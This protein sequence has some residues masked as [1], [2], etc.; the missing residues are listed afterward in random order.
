MDLIV[1]PTYQE[2]ATVTGLVDRILGVAD[3]ASFHVLVVDDASPDGT[4]DIVR[5]HP[6][7]GDRLLLLRRA[8]K[9]GLG[10]AYRDGFAWAEQHG[11]A[12]VV[13]MDADGSHPPESVPDLV[14]ALREAD[15]A[16]GSRYVPG[17]RTVNWPWRRRLVSRAGNLYVQFLLGLPVRD[18]T[19]GFRAYRP[20]VLAAIAPDGTEASGYSFQIETTWRATRSGLR[21]VEVPI[22]FVERQQGSS[23]M[24]TSIAVEALWRVFAWRFLSPPAAPVRARVQ[25]V[26]SQSTR[27]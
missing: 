8:G 5:A 6:A 19:A 3:L 17:G 25:V 1:I 16:I 14:D 2:A 9:D 20:G 13:Q 10:T 7:Y 4:A 26:G 27:R 11:Y 23:K 12:V 24:T 15:V 18:A 22:T 21:L